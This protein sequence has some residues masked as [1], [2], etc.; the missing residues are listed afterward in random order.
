VLRIACIVLATVC[1]GCSLSP[2]VRSAAGT[3]P[4]RVERDSYVA[5]RAPAPV[6]APP[7]EGP[8]TLADL[9]RLV[10]AG[11]VEVQQVR[12][13][14]ESAGADVRRARADLLPN[15]FLEANA[16]SYARQPGSSVFQTD[17]HVADGTIEVSVPLDIGGSLAESV[18]AAQARYRSAAE[19]LKAVAREQRLLVAQAY[20]TLLEAQDLARVNEAAVLLQERALRDGRARLEVGTI[21]KS[22]VLVI[23]VALSNSR[24]RTVTL[25]SAIVSA[26]RALNA[27]TGLPI[28]HPTEV[29]PFDRLIAPVADVVPLLDRARHDNPEV[30]VLIETR[31]AL[32]HELRSNARAD[33]PEVSLGPRLTSTTEGIAMPAENFL[34]FLSVSWNP[35]LNGRLQAERRGLRAQLIEVAWTVTGL[36]RRLEEQILRSHETTVERTSAVR[37]AETSLGQ[38]Q[39]NVRILLEQFRAGV[40]TGREVL[41]AQALLSQ[42]EGTVKTAGHQV[43]AAQVELWYLAGVDPLDYVEQLALDAT[44]RPESR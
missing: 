21:R 5:C 18:R 15:L 38:A 43:N 16:I 39:E 34:G 1:A 6:P 3:P 26:R 13:Q 14:V 24:Q 11:S 12:A 37:A 2:D 29:A 17:R 31:S 28:D 20:F 8:A 36:L 9:L 41:E 7:R 19:R 44:S 40:S 35:D 32:L 23:E 30:D 27:A 25:A 42:Q 33:W 22:D 10:D 4:T